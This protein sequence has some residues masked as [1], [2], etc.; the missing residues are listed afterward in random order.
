M[1]LL[2]HEGDGM[3]IPDTLISWIFCHLSLTRSFDRNGSE[4]MSKQEI[5][6]RPKVISLLILS[7]PKRLIFGTI[8]LL[9]ES[10]PFIDDFHVAISTAAC[11]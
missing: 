3:M 2:E 7:N 5:F 6:I 10:A 9:L 8:A 1:L 4:L 11:L